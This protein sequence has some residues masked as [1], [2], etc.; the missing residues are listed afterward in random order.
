MGSGASTQANAGSSTMQLKEGVTQEYVDEVVVNTQS[1]DGAMNY[2]QQKFTEFDVNMDSTLDYGEFVSFVRKLKLGLKPKEMYTFQREMDVNGDGHISLD[3][4]LSKGP[5]ILQKIYDNIAESP[6]DW[7]KLVK[8][9]EIVYYNKRTGETAYEAPE[10][11]VDYDDTQDFENY[12]PYDA[13]PEGAGSLEYNQGQEQYDENAQ[14]PQ[15][16]HE[17]VE[18]LQEYP[19]EGYEEQQQ[20]EYPQEGYEEQQQQEYPQEGYEEL[21]EGQ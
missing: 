15:D 14:I 2:L 7:C 12:S 11:Y 18:H 5:E 19:Q 20:Q 6:Y 3:E 9:E 4:F 16:G 10:G 1:Y 21:Q 13:S 17:Q 8:E